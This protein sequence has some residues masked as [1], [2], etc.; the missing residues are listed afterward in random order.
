[1]KGWLRD[2]FDLCKIGLAVHVHLLSHPFIIAPP[3]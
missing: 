2:V 3:D 1:M